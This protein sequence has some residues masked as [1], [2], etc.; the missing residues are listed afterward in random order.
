MKKSAFEQWYE[1]EG[2]KLGKPT[3]ANRM[4]CLNAW[5][6]LSARGETPTTNA[7]VALILHR[8]L[9]ETDRAFRV[10]LKLVSGCFITASEAAN[11]LAKALNSLL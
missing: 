1:S 6:E 5:Q 10:N 11:K 8:S 4:R 2:I 9:D 7:I 3:Y